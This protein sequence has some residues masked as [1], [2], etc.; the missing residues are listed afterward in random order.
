M[1]LLNILKTVVKNNTSLGYSKGTET[2]EKTLTPLGMHQG[3]VVTL[4]EIDTALAAADGS[5]CLMPKGSQVVHAVGKYSLWGRDV[6]H[7]YFGSTGEFVQLITA[8]D[9]QTVLQARYWHLRSEIQP[10]TGEEWEFWLGSWQKDE[11]GEFIRDNKGVAIKKEDGLI[12]FPQ[13][14]VDTVPAIVYDREWQAGS[15]AVDPVKFTETLLD[16]SGHKHYIKHEAMEY[17]RKLSNDADSKVESL[18]ASVVEDKGGASIN[19][20]IGIPLDYTAIK[21]LAS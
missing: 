18:L 2:I 5:I 20:W 13:F 11:R 17:S 9:S 16:A 19:I 8:A 12:G 10:I 1:G 21:V 15:N 6:Y 3:S 14:Q 4:S 7:C